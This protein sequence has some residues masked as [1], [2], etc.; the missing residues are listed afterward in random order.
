MSDFSV[1]NLVLGIIGTVTG[2]IA[3]FIHFW[4]LRRESPRLKIEVLK[5]EHDFEEKK[6]TVSFWVDL[7]VKNLGDRGTSRYGMDLTFEDNGK[8]RRLEMVHYGRYTVN[9]IKQKGWISPHETI[10]ISETVYAR[11]EGD[12]KEQ[13]DCTLTIYHTHGAEKVK[14]V[15]KKREQ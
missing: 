2:I 7:Q 13:I 10:K 9:D 14:T 3:L 15:S 1:V 11:Y 5:C 8:E 4:K 12:K 6:K